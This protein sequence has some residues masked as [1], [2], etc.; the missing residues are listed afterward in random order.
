MGSFWVLEENIFKRCHLR[1]LFPRVQWERGCPGLPPLDAFC[2]KVGKFQDPERG[3]VEA[4]LSLGEEGSGG[5][6]R[7][8]KG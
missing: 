2:T 5:E 3:T 1:G 6:R 7:E 4:R 8:P